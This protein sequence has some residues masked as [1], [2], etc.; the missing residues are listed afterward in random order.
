LTVVAIT[1][2]SMG[3]GEACAMAWATRGA[4]LVLNARSE[5]AL[6][7]VAA[8]AEA[9]GAKVVTI[10]GDVRHAS[11]QQ[12]IV[13]AA[14]Q[15]FGGLDVLVNNAGVGLYGAFTALREPMLADV[16]S[17]NVFAPIALTQ[18]ALPLLR[19]SRGTIVMMSSI[20]G[21]VAPPRSGG[22]AASKWAL[23]AIS[24]SLRAELAATRSGVRVCVVRPGVTETPFPNNAYKAEGITNRRQGE[25][26]M[27][28]GVVADAT[29]DAVERGIAEVNL[30]LEGHAIAAIKRLSRPLARRILIELGKRMG[31]PTEG[32]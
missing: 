19:E 16:F 24:E 21:V 29:I 3:I 11:V 22:Y 14:S 10:V 1:G 25:R 18:C 20:V 17:L 15:R 28:P 4:R 8:R 30:T 6:V 12:A 9:S 7:E 13:D 32:G 5:G 26:A 23:E 31:L 27:K 2:A